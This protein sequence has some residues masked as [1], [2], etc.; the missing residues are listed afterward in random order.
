MALLLIEKEIP[1]SV[2]LNIVVTQ[3]EEVVPGLISQPGFSEE[4][5][6]LIFKLYR[7]VAD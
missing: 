4:Q 2:G 5:L 6:Y 3:S 7:D 1:E